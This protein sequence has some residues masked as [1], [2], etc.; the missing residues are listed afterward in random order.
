MC[1]LRGKGN[2][3]VTIISIYRVCKQSS[4]GKNTITIQQQRDIQKETGDLVNARNKYTE[5]MAKIIHYLQSMSHH[6]IICGDANEDMNDRSQNNT[7]RNMLNNCN[8]RLASDIKFP[9]ESLPITYE[10]GKKC[11]D[12]IALSAS[13][14]ISIIQG[15]GYL[16]Y[17]DPIPSDHRAVYIDLDSKVLFGTQIPD[18]TKSTFRHFNTRNMR[19]TNKYLDELRRH[20]R[21]YNM[22]QKVEDLRNDISTNK[23]PKDTLI[24]KCKILEKK[25]NELM[26]AA[27]KSLY[28]GKYNSKHWSSSTLQHA[29]HTCFLLKKQRRYML[30]REEFTNAELD[31]L[32]DD[33]A[34]ATLRLQQC[35]QDSRQNRDA[36]L[37]YNSQEL[38]GQWKVTAEQAKKILLHAEKSK[39][40]FRKLKS[41]IKPNA[42]SSLKTVMVPKPCIELEESVNDDDD[43]SHRLVEVVDPSQVFDITLKRNADSLM[44]SC[45]AVSATGPIS[46][47]MGYD[48]GNEDFTLSLIK[49][50]INIHEYSAQYPEIQQELEA[51][52]QA[53]S[54]PAIEEMQWDFGRV[55]YQALFKKHESQRPVVHL[56]CI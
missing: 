21:N 8:M 43:P 49:G 40:M 25:M 47:A 15:M 55:E 53:S 52:L 13:L 28:K 30:N 19:Q 5:D 27:E 41:I 6:I 42:I 1:H 4:T 54:N 37:E 11:L 44:R 46:D 32:E 7:W 24:S 20:L 14:P 34:A 3:V 31:A 50:T 36:D 35:Q 18:I 51:F 17:S 38:A 56:A 26:T 23:Y 12:M 16:P 2:S 39:K 45:E 9:G 29:A 10:R 22:A 48:N 33:I